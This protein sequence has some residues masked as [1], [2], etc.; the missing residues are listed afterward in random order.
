MG[1]A[2]AEGLWTPERATFVLSVFP[3]ACNAL[4]P[5]NERHSW[6][7]V[8]RQECDPFLAPVA[9]LTSPVTR[10]QTP[11]SQPRTQKKTPLSMLLFV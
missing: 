6:G 2:S 9:I 7:N 5:Q 3:A 10:H 8:Q 11:Q 4:A 1:E